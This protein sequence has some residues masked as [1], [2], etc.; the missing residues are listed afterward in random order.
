MNRKLVYRICFGLYAA[1]FLYLL[2]WLISC[3]IHMANDDFVCFMD[4]YSVSRFL[5]YYLYA[6]LIFTGFEIW[7]FLGGLPVKL[8]CRFILKD[9]GEKSSEMVK[10]LKPV[11]YV[12]LALHGLMVLD[13]IICTSV[14]LQGISNMLSDPNGGIVLIGVFVMGILIT[15]GVVWLAFSAVMLV[16]SVP[17]V[18]FVIKQLVTAWIGAFNIS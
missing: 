8:I 3:V 14:S 13:A 4:D 10:K 9:R 1:W 15:G 7:L 5:S 11:E 17:M 18:K 2:I 6:M 12:V 16:I